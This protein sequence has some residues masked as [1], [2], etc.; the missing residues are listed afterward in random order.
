[1]SFH[2][3]NQNEQMVAVIETGRL[4]LEL[5]HASLAAAPGRDVTLPVRVARGKGLTGPVRIEAV[6]PEHWR[7]VSAEPVVVAADQ[8]KATLTLRFATGAIGPFN[9]PLVV[10]AAVVEAK[11]RAVAEARLELVLEA[12][13]RKR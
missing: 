3:V 7:G 1:V 2:S 4:G 10:R 13:E 6:I 12:P 9:A 8:E 5:G 11:E